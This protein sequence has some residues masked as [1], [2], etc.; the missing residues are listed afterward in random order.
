MT[1][2]LL[3]MI[4]SYQRNRESF[5]QALALLPADTCGLAILSTGQSSPSS[6]IILIL[7]A[8][9]CEEESAAQAK[10]GLAPNGGH[11]MSN[12]RSA[13]GETIP[14]FVRLLSGSKI[15]NSNCQNGI[16]SRRKASCSIRQP[17]GT[18]LFKRAITVFTGQQVK[19][20]T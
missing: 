16:A 13:K 6:I 14:Q 18:A 20:Q 7:E 17:E 12:E 19:G 8:F 10:C 4:K 9:E 11:R 1:N 15:N 2:R 3:G 5:A